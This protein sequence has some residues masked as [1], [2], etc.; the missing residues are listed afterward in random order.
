MA[1]DYYEILDV[2]RGSSEDEIKKAYRKL[3]LKYHPDRAPEDKKKEY[4]E[5]FKEISQAYSILS[6]KNKREQYDKFGKT[7]ENGQGGFGSGFSQQDFGHFYDAFGGKNSFEDLGLNDIFGEIFGFKTR[8]QTKQSVQY[9]QDIQIDIVIDLEDAFEGVKKEIEIRKSVTCSK[10]GGKGGES[11]KKCSFCQGSGYEQV[12]SQSIF[13][14][15]VQQRV[16]SHCNGRGEIPEKVCSECRG[17]GVVKENI[18]IGISIPAGIDNGQ[19]IKLSGQ[20]ETAP[21]GGQAGDLFARIRVRPHKYFERRED[22]IY[23]N[24]VINF[25]QASLGDKIE[26]PTL[27]KSIRIKIPSGTQ[28]GEII[29]LK[30]K[31]MPRLYGRGSG[32]LLVRIK[33][34]V[35]KRLSWKQKKLIKELS[36]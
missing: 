11:L 24:L 31:G 22:N 12:K 3:A 1:K 28:P 27:S 13:G 25:A 34:N 9:G 30:G 8:R 4:E 10:C 20:G 36:L 23:Y 6:D 15:I 18:K 29:K 7:F 19:T 2:P 14:I 17:Q 35:P 16:C 33:V 32:D 5:K 26:I 21:Y